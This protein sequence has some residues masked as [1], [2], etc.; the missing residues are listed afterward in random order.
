MAAGVLT[1][2]MMMLMFEQRSWED[3]LH[4]T[5]ENITEETIRMKQILIDPFLSVNPARNNGW[6]GYL[7]GNKL[8]QGGER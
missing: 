7:T 3:H 8:T 6:S 1:A 4:S 2:R 5:Q